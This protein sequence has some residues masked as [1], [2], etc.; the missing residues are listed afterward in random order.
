M[1]YYQPIL[2][3]VT[4]T[5]LVLVCIVVAASL[6]E[7]RRCYRVALGCYS[8]VALVA[9]FQALVPYIL[10]I[11][12]ANAFNSSN[13]VPV[14]GYILP[15]L[16]FVGFIYPALSLYPFMSGRS[17]RIVAF[18]FAGLSVLFAIGSFVA[19]AVRWPLTQGGGMYYQSGVFA[20]FHLLLWLRVY[21][22]RVASETE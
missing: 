4:V 5:C 12:M 16:I 3:Y 17:G 21:D 1:E 10:G 9:G 20:V 2:S 19:E 15:V 18:T 7:S 13:K 14:T 22:L 6:Y 11:S 8:V